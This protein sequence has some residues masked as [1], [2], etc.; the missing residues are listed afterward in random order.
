[1]VSRKDALRAARGLLAA[2]IAAAVVFQLQRSVDS[3]FEAVNFFSFFTILSNVFAAAFLAW[4]VARPPESQG[5]VGASVRGAMT[6]Y[7]CITGIVYAV[8]LGPADIGGPEP[9]VNVVVHFVAP[10]AVVLDWIVEP[11][12]NLP[13]RRVA[14]AWLAWPLAYVAYT[15]IRGRIVDWYPYPFL[16]PRESG[17]YAGVLGY[18]VAVFAAFVGVG[19]ALHWWTTR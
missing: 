6:L 15:L 14:V 8:L 7:M 18:S 16:D 4:Q 13:G 1:V 11:P 12:R 5:R 10:I 19:L 17:G 2:L 9:W 3:A